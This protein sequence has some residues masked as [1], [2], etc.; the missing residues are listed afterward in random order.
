MTRRNKKL[1]LMCDQKKKRQAVPLIR[2]VVELIVWCF[3]SK[4][5]QLAGV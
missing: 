1:A 2:T 4:I 5:I 3:F